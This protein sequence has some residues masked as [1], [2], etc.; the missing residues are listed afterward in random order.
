MTWAISKPRCRC[1]ALFFL[2]H[3][4]AEAC[5][6]QSIAASQP[7]PELVLQTGHVGGIWAV[8]F[9]PDGRWLASGGADQKVK[10]WDVRTWL[11]L[12]TLSGETD[13]VSS[14]AFQPARGW[15]AAG[16]RKN[17][18]HLWDASK[19]TPPRKLGI[20]G[21]GSVRIAFSPE[22]RWLA[23]GDR[24]GRVIIWDV[25]TAQLVR[26]LDGHRSD[27]DAVA[28]SQDGLVLASAGIDGIKLWDPASGKQ[29]RHLRHP[30]ASLAFS[31]DGKI[32]AAGTN[33]RTVDL[34]EVE[35]GSVRETLT[36]LGWSVWSVSFSPDGRWLAAGGGQAIKVWRWPELSHVFDL[37]GHT[38]LIES[39]AFGP[40]GRWLASAGRDSSIKVWNLAT[41]RLQATLSGYAGPVQEVEFSRDGRWLALG[42][43]FDDR[44]R[45]DDS[46]KIWDA[47]TGQ[48]V[49]DIP[50]GGVYGVAELAFSADGHAV[51]AAAWPRLPGGG[52]HWI[53]KSWE[54][55]TGRQLQ[56]E[57]LGRELESQRDKRFYMAGVTRRQL[58]AATDPQ[59]RVQISVW[60]D[61][62]VLIR[63]VNSGEELAL[64]SSMP[65]GP[66]WIVVTPDGLFDGSLDGMRELVG[67]RFGNETAP[68]EVFFNEF[69]YPGLLAD[70][71]AG[72]RPKAPRDF[73]QLDRRQPDVKLAAGS[74]QAAGPVA[75]RNL[76]LKLEV[77]E[78]PADASR[79]SGSGARDVRLFRNGSL[80]KVWR[81]DVL[82]GQPKVTLEAS[83]PI[84]AGPNRFTA[85]A[86]NKDNI[87]SSDA[88]LVVSGAE[89]L[90]R[91]ATAYV[92]AVGINQY[93]NKDYNLNYAVADAQVFAEE[94]ARQQTK[95]GEYA[96]VEVI[97]LLDKD[98]TK[99]NLLAALRKLAG[100]TQPTSASAKPSPLPAALAKLE[101]A[102]PED[103]VFVYYAGH[104]TASGPRFY[105]IPHDLGYTGSRTEIDEAGLKA[106]LDHSISDRDLEQAFEKID[107]GRLLLVIDACNSGQALEAE[108]KRRGPMNSK[109]LAQLAYEKGMYVLT[110][111]QGYQAALEAAQLGHGYLTYA[112]VEEGLKTPS[113]D[114]SPKDGSVVV[115]EWLDYAMLRVPQM[116]EQGMQDARKLG[117][118]LAIVE[119][120]EKIDDP[121]QRSLQRPRVFYRREPEAQP[122][123]VAKP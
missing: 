52:K 19:E 72:K 94:L 11:E 46:M 117:R 99:A 109:G 21:D 67:W 13:W 2:M 43:G 14:L 1:L 103:A 18:V 92:L 42:S 123:V 24:R 114:S 66:D 8:A 28:F 91:K 56:A 119:G 85:Y 97:P 116:Q 71:L 41:G 88:E 98:A 74:A 29:L 36:G 63:E 4:L 16:D 23:T 108:E 5:H 51:S 110:A 33:D 34:W 27:V 87:K 118:N 38:E 40:E 93:A 39:I 122:L 7:R 68:L 121:A 44:Q 84:V 12:R 62:R 90:R 50:T 15:L 76:F 45:I 75:S 89:S 86:F 32:L 78:A 107:A 79:P 81:G 105:L 111:A 100:E 64:L 96:K 10:L 20:G 115:R 55:A 61:G 82:K 17:T 25:A 54:V 104:G 70:V 57:P 9:S 22:G 58:D 59:G 3:L 102:Q 80:V 65:V 48:L 77:A 73:A 49:H 83:L 113:A 106:I 95:L 37:A 60:D 53:R 47:K 30:A 101:P 69:Y 26:S 6:S 31:P 112:L 120:E 35:S